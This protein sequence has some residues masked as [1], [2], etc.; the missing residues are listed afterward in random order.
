MSPHEELDARKTRGE[1]DSAIGGI[2][3]HVDYVCYI[4]PTAVVVDQPFS[5]KSEQSMID[6]HVRGFLQ[7]ESHG[8]VVHAIRS[9]D[10]DPLFGVFSEI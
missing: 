9:I 2:G 5:L 3:H 4:T 1:Y 8:F 6:G 7:R 10:A